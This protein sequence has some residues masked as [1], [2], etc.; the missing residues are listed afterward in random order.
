[1]HLVAKR[2][3]LIRRLFPF[4]NVEFIQSVY[5]FYSVSNLLVIQHLETLYLGEIHVRVVYEKV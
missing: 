1:M 5:W 3:L 2:G 4:C